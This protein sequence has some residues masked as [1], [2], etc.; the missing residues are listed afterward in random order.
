MLMPDDG[1]M[2]QSAALDDDVAVAVVGR[3]QATHPTYLAL[4]LAV[5]TDAFVTE[6]LEQFQ[7]RALQTGGHAAATDRGEVLDR[8][9][10]DATLALGQQRGLEGDGLPIDHA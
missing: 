9:L 2:R 10:A 3:L 7:H 1:Q 8:P 6:A 5:E 4:Q